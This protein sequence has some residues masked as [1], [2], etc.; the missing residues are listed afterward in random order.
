[1]QEVEDGTTS[2]AGVRGS[3]KVTCMNE[4]LAPLL[5]HVHDLSKLF[6]L[7]LVLPPVGGGVV[8]YIGSGLIVSMG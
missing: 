5:L 6:S 4:L 2:V 7:F 1:M 3:R 8:A